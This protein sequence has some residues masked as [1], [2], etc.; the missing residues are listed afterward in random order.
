MLNDNH[1]LG[2]IMTDTVFDGEAKEL[3]A[4]VLRLRDRLSKATTFTVQDYCSRTGKE[5]IVVERRDTDKWALLIGHQVL[6]RDG[7]LCIE[8]HPSNRSE[9]FFVKYRWPLDEA[10]T[11]AEKWKSRLVNGRKEENV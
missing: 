3:A 8:P 5:R 7:T 10:L 6:G 2:V 9:E 11:E 1:L 4:E